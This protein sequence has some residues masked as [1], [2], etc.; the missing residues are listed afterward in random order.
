MGPPTQQTP[1]LGMP[2]ILIGAP[3]SNTR[4]HSLLY[5]I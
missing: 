3:F 2:E 1:I 5:R 4:E